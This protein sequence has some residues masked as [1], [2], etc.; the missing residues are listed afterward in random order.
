MHE[1]GKLPKVI[2]STYECYPE[3]SASGAL[4]AAINDLR[5]AHRLGLGCEIKS[6]HSKGFRHGGNV[7]K[8]DIYLYEVTVGKVETRD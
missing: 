4:E 3:G 1:F 6:V 5:A 8:A 7:N 2:T